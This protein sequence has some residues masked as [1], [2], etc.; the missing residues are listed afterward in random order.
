M[1][2]LHVAAEFSNLEIMD[3]LI[4]AGANI[5]VLDSN[6][7]TPLFWAVA[8]HKTEAAIHLMDIGADVNIQNFEET[9]LI[10]SV[11]ENDVKCV[12]HLVELGANINYQG[13]N[14]ITALS[15]AFEMDT[16]HIKE[17]LLKK[18][19]KLPSKMAVQYGAWVS[20]AWI[21]RSCYQI[22]LKA[23]LFVLVFLCWAVLWR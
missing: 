7:T 22:P 12:E 8:R 4:K 13:H 2:A 11:Y 3:C 15:V 9:P 10:R 14:N 1:S 16:T 17:I 6:G 19:A 5:N 18:V 23:W 21:L 20:V